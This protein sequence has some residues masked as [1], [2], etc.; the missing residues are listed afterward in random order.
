MFRCIQK[1]APED[2][3]GDAPFVLVKDIMQRLTQQ[4]PTFSIG[5]YSDREIGEMLL[6]MGCQ[7]K[8]QTK[9][10]SPQIK[11]MPSLKVKQ[12][13]LPSLRCLLTQ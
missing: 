13:V 7:S 4:F 10:L 12:L 1:H 9:G 2:T 3:P 6:S 8:R 11:E 5:K